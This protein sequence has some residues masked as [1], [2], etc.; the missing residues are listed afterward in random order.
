MLCMAGCPRLAAPN[1]RQVADM[2]ADPG[3]SAVGG[4]GG[5][6]G[7]DAAAAHG[8]GRGSSETATQGGDVGMPAVVEAEGPGGAG[9]GCESGGKNWQA[10]VDQDDDGAEDE[11]EGEQVKMRMMGRV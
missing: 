9:E 6:G 4:G 11:G 2:A 3:A 1:G 8:A 5:G 10:I 7:D